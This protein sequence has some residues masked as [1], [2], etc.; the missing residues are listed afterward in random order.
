MRAVRIHET[1]GPEA[2]RVEDVEVPEPAEGQVRVRHAAI[3]VNFID[4]YHRSGLYE[5][6]SLPHGLGVEAAGVVD[7]VG[8]GVTDFTEGD[9]VAYFAG[10]PGAYAEA[11]CIPAERLVKVPAGVD[12]DDAAASLLKGMT[13]E[14]LIH[15]TFEVEAGMTVLFHAAAGGVGLIACQWLR[16]LGVRV[17]GTVSTEAKAA[18][19]KE[20]GMA[21]AIFYTRE[22]VA[23]RV[24]ALTDGEG[25]PVV[26]DSVGKATLD[27]SLA[28][29]R[30]R[31]LLVA[32]GNA[33]GAPEPFD[34]M[35]LA[36]GGSLFLTRPSLFDYTRSRD[37]LELS[38]G[39]VFEAIES[40]AVTPHI[41]ARF[42][43]DDAESCHRALEARETVGSTLLIPPD[44][45]EG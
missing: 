6:P 36:R 44:P 17:L 24:R 19:A 41:G 31:G 10:P 43:L 32:F 5:L 2:L 9:R 7:A 13:V 14:Y 30:P 37:E 20:H 18:L 40:G 12:L 39:R 11:K 23:E 28:C 42:A 15:R 45:A 33:S 16:H 29:L 3:G 4:T 22:D 21:E 26:Y 35:A 34:P 8:A 38:A 1:G 25:V 27:A